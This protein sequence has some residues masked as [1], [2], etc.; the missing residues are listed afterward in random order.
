MNLNKKD[1]IEIEF[2]GKIKDGEVFDSNIKSEL[3]K[4]NPGK[5]VKARPFIFALGE[6]MFLAG[7]DDFLIGKPEPAKPMRYNIE[8]QPEKAFGNRNR[9]LIQL[10]PI[11]VFH[12]QKISPIPGTPF[13]FDGRVAKILSV[14]GGRVM[15]DF[16]HPLAGKTLVYDLNVKRKIIDTAEKAK[17]L[18]EFFFR[19]ELKFKI[20]GKKLILEVEKPF[21][22]YAKLFKDKFKELL[23]LELQTEE[24]KKQDSKQPKTTS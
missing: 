8:L 7:V 18:I 9:N 17:A 2:V 13:N 20:E 23:G 1:F 12:E 11:K 6:D 5:S 3:E 10:I 19:Q 21:V 24:I 22:E 14:S 4:L 15:A 16:N